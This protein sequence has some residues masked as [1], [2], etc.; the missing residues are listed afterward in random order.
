MAGQNL[1]GSIHYWEPDLYIDIYSLGLSEQTVDMMRR[2]RN[3]RVRELKA[4]LPPHV[5]EWGRYAF[6]PLVIQDALDRHERV[7][8]GGGGEEEKRAAPQH[9][10][11]EARRR[12]SESHS[13]ADSPL[14]LAP[15]R[16]P[17]LLLLLLRC[18]GL[19]PM[20]SCVGPW[21]RSSEHCR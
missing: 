11:T 19:T 18:F 16:H 8:K 4:P 10:A 5:S 12:A 1:I 3:V 17:M 14:F 7:S 2:W 21:T 6:K 15:H 9:T 20:P 13:Q